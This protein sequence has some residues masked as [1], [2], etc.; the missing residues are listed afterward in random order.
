MPASRPAFR[1]FPSS[2]RR[3]IGPQ[4]SKAARDLIGEAGALADRS[5]PGSGTFRRFTALRSRGSMSMAPGKAVSWSA[6]VLALA[7]GLLAQPGYAQEQKATKDEVFWEVRQRQ[8]AGAAAQLVLAG[9]PL[10]VA[11]L[12][13][14]GL[15]WKVWL[16]PE[17]LGESVPALNPEWLELVRDGTPMPNFRGKADDEKRADQ[18]A[19]YKVWSQAVINAFKTPADAFAKSAEENSHVT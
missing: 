2:P 12:R 5:L 6:F 18:V 16:E 3:A 17:F 19:I 15:R 7:A 1:T 9:N 4:R 13:D 14:E 10:A 8:E 11:V